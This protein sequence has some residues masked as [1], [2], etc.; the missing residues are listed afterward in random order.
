M[1]EM[2]L[3]FTPFAPKKADNITELFANIAASKV[4][5]RIR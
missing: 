1:Y 5:Y 2:F 4:P 3:G